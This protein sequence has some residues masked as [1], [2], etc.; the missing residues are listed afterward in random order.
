MDAKEGGRMSEYI[1]ANRLKTI[2]EIQRADFNSIETIREW[3]DSQ[4]PADVREN[5]H[6]EWLNDKNESVEMIDG[7]PQET[8]WC[9]NCKEW[10]TAS[11]EYECYGNYCPKC[12]ADMRTE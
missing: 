5:V 10:L 2:K 12:G 3:I 8:C 11:D 7:I 9:S 4:P 1:N 6:G